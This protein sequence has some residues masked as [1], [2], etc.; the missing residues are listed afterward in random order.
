MAHDPEKT[1]GRVKQV[2]QMLW[3]GVRAEVDACSQFVAR[4]KNPRRADQ[5]DCNSHA[6]TGQWA[7]SVS[8]PKATDLSFRP[9]LDYPRGPEECVR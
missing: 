6:W 4:F 9:L 5:R 7:L 2:F 3:R 8:C 1:R